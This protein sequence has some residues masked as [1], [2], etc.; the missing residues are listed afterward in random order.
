MRYFGLLLSIFLVVLLLSSCKK[1]SCFK[2]VGEESTVE[3]DSPAFNK[4]RVHDFVDVQLKESTDHRVKLRGGTNLLPLIEINTEGE[5]L[6]I[7]N[8]NRCSWMRDA[9]ERVEVIIYS[10]SIEK[11]EFLG[12]GDLRADDLKVQKME[13][14]TFRSL[15]DL[16]FHVTADS[17]LFFLEQGAPDIYLEGQTGYLYIYHV[18]T[19]R[20]FAE[21]LQVRDQIHLNH[22][23]TG[24]F[25]VF[26]QQKLLIEIKGSGNIY[27]YHK[28]SELTIAQIGRGMYIPSY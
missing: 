12:Y 21:G 7:K 28:P 14:R 1:D 10:P 13:L 19:G 9:R 16:N 18:G 24:H 26:P 6:V 5:T 27:S 25:H 2:S 3:M 15:R 17:L 23:S 4:L 20:V 11:I 22:E 8:S